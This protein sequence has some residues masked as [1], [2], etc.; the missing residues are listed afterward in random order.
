MTWR[1]I[2]SG[3]GSSNFPVYLTRRFCLSAFLT[4]QQFANSVHACGNPYLH[5]HNKTEK[6]FW[7]C[8]REFEPNP[9]QVF[10]GE[11]PLLYSRMGDR[12]LDHLYTRVTPDP[13]TERSP[14]VVRG[15]ETT[16]GRRVEA[17]YGLTRL[18]LLGGKESL[19]PLDQRFWYRVGSVFVNS[20]KP[21][22]LVLRSQNV[23]TYI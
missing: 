22:G 19:S 14:K 18:S 17:L 11:V 20:M 7:Q 10:G 23:C 4:A 6:S 5:W 8:N 21:T 2:R 3:G 1:S 13:F 9:R 16:S 12:W 15:I